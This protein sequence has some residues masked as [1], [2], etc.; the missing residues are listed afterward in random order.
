VAL[1]AT[2]SPT[3]LNDFLLAVPHKVAK[4]DPEDIITPR[5]PLFRR[6]E[7]GDVKGI[8]EEEPGQGPVSDFTYATP[9]ATV[10]LSANKTSTTRNL[11]EHQSSTRAQYD[12]VMAVTTLTLNMYDF[13]NATT[14]KE[15][16]VDWFRRKKVDK[17]REHR[18]KQVAYLWDGA[19]V[20]G[21]NVF[22]LNDVIRFD[23]TADPSKGA[24]GKVAYADCNDWTNQSH[25]YNTAYAVYS[26]GAMTTTFL[27]NGAN[28]LTAAYNACANF[29]DEEDAQPDI[30]VCNEIYERCCEALVEKGLIF[31]DSQDTFKLGITPF[32][33]KNA[34]LFYDRN[35]NDDPNTSTYGVAYL[36]NTRAFELI[37]ARGIRNAWQGQVKLELETA[38]IYDKITQLSMKWKHLGKFGVHYG[39]IP[40][41]SAA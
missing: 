22:G 20:N 29:G 36:L 2:L 41:V 15:K 9:S 23:P 32:V 34:R 13:L 3:E 12:W 25:N 11:T 21:M 5:N 16:L 24:I 40:T 31:R 26:S 18:N 1:P 6:L 7:S 8:V 17:D 30:I 35:V 28:S 19:A 4:M 10:E 38:V 27:S 37:Y 33:F 14:T 39:V